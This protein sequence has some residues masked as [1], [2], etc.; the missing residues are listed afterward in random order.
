MG[1]IVIHAYLKKPVLVFF[2][3]FQTDGFQGYFVRRGEN[4]SAV[5]YRADKMK[6]E[7]RFVM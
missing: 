2:S 1:M 3:Q 4:L 6:D 7:Q 5:F